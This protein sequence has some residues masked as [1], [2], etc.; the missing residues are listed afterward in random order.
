MIGLRSAILVAL[1]GMSSVASTD[2][3]RG[4]LGV[5]ADVAPV[6]RLELASREPDLLLTADDLDRG[7]IESPQ[8][9]HLTVY[10]N[11]RSG[12]ALDVM[13]VSPL[14]S[15]VSVQGLDTDV[16][17]SAGGG[18]VTQRWGHPQK[19]SLELRFSFVIAEGVQ[20]GRYPWPVRLAARPL[21][22]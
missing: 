7:Y 10:S 12:Y 20:P 4:T 17:L 19:V 8:P 14:F 9:L 1:L 21:D 3:A 2:Q 5:S 15:A 6:A 22:Q 18:T 16:R 13:P 11:S